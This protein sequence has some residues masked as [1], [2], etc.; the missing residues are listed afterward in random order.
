[1]PLVRPLEAI[2]AVLVTVKLTAHFGNALATF[3]TR[4]NED[5]NRNDMM[6]ERRTKATR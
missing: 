5:A 1:M 2:E 4:M 6:K 3:E